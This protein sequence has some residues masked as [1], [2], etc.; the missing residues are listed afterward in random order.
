MI[1]A[2]VRMSE[3]ELL[4][5]LRRRRMALDCVAV[6]TL[7]LAALAWALSTPPPP[8][9]HCGGPV[10]LEPVRVVE[11]LVEPVVVVEERGQIV[12]TVELVE[13]P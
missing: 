9:A 3:T 12:T 11:P 6:A 5:D 4:H 10:V 8:P 1:E 7:A 2:E 13:E